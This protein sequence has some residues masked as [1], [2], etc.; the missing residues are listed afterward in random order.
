MDPVRRVLRAHVVRS[1]DLVDPDLTGSNPPDITQRLRAAG[2]VFA[3]READVLRAR[4]GTDGALLDRL[5]TRRCAGEPLE[6][7]VGYADFAGIRA[8]VAK[9]VFVPRARSTALVERAVAVLDALEPAER[10]VVDLGCGTGALGAAVLARIPGT[11]IAV[12]NDPAAVACARATLTGTGALVVAGDLFA[13]VPAVLRGRVG[14]VLA[15][16]PYV[17]TAAMELLPREARDYEARAAL[18]GG[19]AGLTPYERAVGELHDWLAPS[20]C[21]LAELHESQVP[22]ATEFAVRAGLAVTATTDPDDGTMV[23]ELR[24]ATRRRR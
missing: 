18:D 4:A 19:P 11:L 3:E 20:G 17:P 6:S 13:A 16:L 7:V 21:Y 22:A 10:I 24:P 14:V 9:G 1:V 5:V 2:C 23:V 8:V 12:D 15:N